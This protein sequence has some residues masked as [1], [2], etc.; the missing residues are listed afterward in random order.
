M[1][2]RAGKP[3]W[4]LFLKPKWPLFSSELRFDCK[5]MA[6]YDA[7]RA[8]VASTGEKLVKRQLS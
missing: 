5:E 3:L 1:R 4:D 2:Q 7:A 6:G 8:R